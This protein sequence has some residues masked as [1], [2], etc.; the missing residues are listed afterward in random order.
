VNVRSPV[1]AL[2]L[3]VA[4]PAADDYPKPT[5]AQKLLE[6]VYGK[7]I[8]A[9]R[10]S[11]DETDDFA[12]ARRLIAAGRDKANPDNVR[13][14]LARAATELV[15]PLGSKQATLLAHEALELL[16]AVEPLDAMEKLEL[17]R[18]I[19]LR[20]LARAQRDRLT[21]DALEPLA[22]TAA[23]AHVECGRHALSEPKLLSRAEQ[24]LLAAKRLRRSYRLTALDFWLEDL[25]EAIKRTRLRSARLRAALAKLKSAEESKDVEEVKRARR[26]V[27]QVYLEFDGDLIS[28]WNYLSGTGD[29]NEEAIKVAAMFALGEGKVD[30]DE[31]LELV[32]KAIRIARR[33]SGVARYKVASCAAG[34]C[35]AYLKAN[36]KG[37]GATKARLLERQAREIGRKF[38]DRELLKELAASY[39]GFSGEVR[40]LAGGRIRVVYDFADDGQMR[41]WA[42][43]GGQWK[44]SNGMLA[45]KPAQAQRFTRANTLNRLRFRCDKPFR[46]AFGCGGR[47]NLSVSARLAYDAADGTGTLHHSFDLSRYGLTSNAFGKNWVNST[48]RMDSGKRYTFGITSDGKGGF[49]WTV[50]GQKAHE[51]PSDDDTTAAAKGSFTLLLGAHPFGTTSFCAFD[52][53]LIEGELLPAEKK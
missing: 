41:E 45:C 17:L 36:S 40:V 42:P 43:Q 4:A 29:P 37:M 19:A 24:E 47:G 20:R 9:A 10:A 26:G 13:A 14:T 27:G 35:Q 52:N 23:R 32:E 46:I 39:D 44:I 21:R 2:L 6:D 51:Q 8:A 7:D 5:E 28:A 48:F 50:D 33:L 18:D 31:S 30:S 49:I 15:M 38:E 16:D 3:V 12:L 22:Q 53:V 25:D 1:L 11:R 34:M